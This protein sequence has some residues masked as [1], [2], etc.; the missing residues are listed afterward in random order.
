MEDIRKSHT[1]Y[2]CQKYLFFYFLLLF[3]LFV[4]L[5][6]KFRIIDIHPWNKLYLHLSFPLR[7]FI[8]TCLLRVRRDTISSL[9]LSVWRIN[10]TCG[11][12]SFILSPSLF[13]SLHIF[14]F[15]IF[16]HKLVFALFL[17]VRLKRLSQCKMWK[18]SENHAVK[19][20]SRNSNF[21]RRCG[22][23]V[24]KK[25]ASTDCRRLTKL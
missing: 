17:C 1:V 9:K 14:S 8:V 15:S 12:N 13:S 24:V 18:K 3:S 23:L 22:P 20:S 10:L 5:R 11:R 7:F 6:W 25:K 19:F 4:C 21:W 16:Y 2:F